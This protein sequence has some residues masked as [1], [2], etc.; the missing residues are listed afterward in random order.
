MRELGHA[1][2][3]KKKTQRRAPTYAAP[4]HC[5][6]VDGDSFNAS[7]AHTHLRAET[8]PGQQTGALHFFTRLHR[9]SARVCSR[10]ATPYR[11][12]P[13]PQSPWRPHSSC[14]GA[15]GP[16]SS[17][18]E[19]DRRPKTASGAR[20]ISVCRAES[21]SAVGRV[22]LTNSLVSSLCACALAGCARA[23]S[24]GGAADAR[25]RSRPTRTLKT[26]HNT[27]TGSSHVWAAQGQLRGRR[28]LAQPGAHGV[29]DEAG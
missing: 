6:T 20:C 16:S 14:R 18:W 24:F 11:N 27:G 1:R 21:L 8:Y 23:F 13:L 19:A 12:A 4:P 5:L 26:P 7:I 3:H 2:P 17:L 29:A 15:L 9:R 28:V 22:L 25:R 10:A